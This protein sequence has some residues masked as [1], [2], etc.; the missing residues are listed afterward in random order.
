MVAAATQAGGDVPARPAIGV[1]LYATPL[2]AG[3]ALVAPERALADL[4]DTGYLLAEEPAAIRV[5][6]LVA[7]PGPQDAV[8]AQATALLRRAAAAAAMSV[9]PYDHQRVSRAGPSG[10]WYAALVV[11]GWLLL[12][13]AGQS[14][15]QAAA[16]LWLAAGL[17]WA[18]RG[19]RRRQIEW[20]ARGADGLRAVADAVEVRQLEH[21]GLVELARLMERHRHD[22]AAACRAVAQSCAAAGLADLAPI[23]RALAAG[24]P[25]ARIWAPLLVPPAESPGP[26]GAPAPA[27]SGEVESGPAGRPPEG[28]TAGPPDG[29]EGATLRTSST[30]T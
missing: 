30:S 24:E 19:S 21:A 28:I 25:P 8:A 14:A 5:D 13:G 26:G 10:R 6:L 20:V 11:W 29:Q 1:R 17:P 16:G 27:D 12:L 3:T 2:P 9:T 4:L 23:Y 22:A 18:R 15:L 7:G